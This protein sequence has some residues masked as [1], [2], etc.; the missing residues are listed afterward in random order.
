MFPRYL[1]PCDKWLDESQGDGKIGRLLVLSSAAEEDKG[2][3]LRRNIRRRFY[4]DHL[5]VSLTN[6]A[7]RT[8]FTRVQRI[9]CILAIFYLSMIT[10][11]M[12]Y[13]DPGD[14]SGSS[15]GTITIGSLQISVNDLITGFI[16]SLIVIIPITFIVC[17]FVYS[18][19]KPKKLDKDGPKVYDSV[20]K[21]GLPGV[22]RIHDKKR[23]FRLPYWFIYVAW[24]LVFLSVAASAFF[25]ILYSFGWGRK[26]STAWLVAFLFSNV[27]NVFFVEPMKVSVIL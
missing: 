26:K 23:V 24:V 8:K 21:T 16:S 19:R 5:W 13:R 12:F 4:N 9:S 7:W 17:G 3:L 14:T 27:S 2:K 20:N 22:H 10:N 1:F 11:A 6:S 18:A 15:A 25:T